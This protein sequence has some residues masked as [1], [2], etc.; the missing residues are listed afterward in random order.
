MRILYAEE[1]GKPPIYAQVPGLNFSFGSSGCVILPFYSRNIFSKKEDAC[2]PKVYLTDRLYSGS[3]LFMRGFSPN[4]IGPRAAAGTKGINTGGIEGGDV[5]GGQVRYNM[6]A[7]LSAPIPVDSLAK[8]GARAFA[9]FSGASVLT[10]ETWVNRDITDLLSSR[11]RA[12]GQTATDGF[13]NSVL[14]STRFCIGW[15][16]SLPIGPARLELSYAIPLVKAPSDTVR[17]FQ[18]GLGLSIS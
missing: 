13:F 14:N 2:H 12:E 16:F 7:A 18:V 9:F 8:H 10:P 15:G 6:L 5:L 3:S 1:D 11:N 17:Q 4:T